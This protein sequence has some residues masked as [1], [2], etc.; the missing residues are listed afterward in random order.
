MKRFSG[1]F[2]YLTGYAFGWG[3]INLT[4]HDYEAAASDLF[5]FVLFLTYVIEDSDYRR[6]QKD[7]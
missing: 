7:T 5:W 6:K 4:Y 1:L 2:P 3:I